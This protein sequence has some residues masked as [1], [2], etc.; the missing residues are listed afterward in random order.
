MDKFDQQIISRLQQNARAS[1]AAI[2]RDIGLSRSAVAERIQR[3]EARGIIQG[4]TLKLAENGRQAV[5]A[6]FQLSF[7]PF[8][9]DELL[10]AIQA[11]PEL[12]SG[13][14]LSGE[15]DLIL[16]AETDSMERLNQI[17]RELEQLPDLKRLLTCPVLQSISP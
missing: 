7:S 5:Q 8:K 14:A 6:Y 10:P 1:L 17:R 4:Y 13:H 3:L 16:F 12:R 2:G 15:V 9:L 11:I